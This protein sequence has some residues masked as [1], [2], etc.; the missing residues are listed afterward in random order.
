M[1]P[2]CQT[3]R[4]PSTVFRLEYRPVY[5]L[6][7]K[8]ELLHILDMLADAGVEAWWYAAAS[9]GSYPMF[10]SRH[11]PYRSDAVDVSYFHWLSEQAHQRNITLFSWEYLTTAPILAQRHPEW[12][13][14]LFDWDGPKTPR[15]HQYVCWNSPYG[16]MLK[17]YSLEVVTDCGFDGIWFDGSFLHG[18]GMT[19]R[20]ACCCE[21]CAKRYHDQTGC[22]LP[23][24]VDLNDQACR[25]YFAWR[26]DDHMRYWQELSSFVKATQP[27]AT[28]AY[29]HFNRLGG[30]LDS[31]TP[32]TKL[33]NDKTSLIATE[34][35]FHY[36]QI[37][38]LAKLLR[39]TSDHYVPELWTYLADSPIA[40]TVNPDPTPLVYYMQSC[41][42]HGTYASFGS[43]RDDIHT[44][45]QT[46]HALGDAARQIRPFIGGKS[47]AK[48]AV[49]FSNAT[50]DYAYITADGK[51]YDNATIW[52]QVC[53]TLSLLDHLHIQSDIIFDNMLNPHDLQPYDAIIL[54]SVKC[55]ADDAA[56]Q[57]TD[58]VQQGGQLLAIG[59][60]GT[61]D[62]W[63]HPRQTPVLDALFGI[64][65]HESKQTL[66]TLPDG[67]IPAGL[68][69]PFRSNAQ[70]TIDC[71][72]CLNPSRPLGPDGILPLSDDSYSHAHAICCNTV[73]NGHALYIA[74]DIVGPYACSGPSTRTR[75]LIKQ[76]LTRFVTPNVITDAPCNVV[77]NLFQNEQHLHVHL[78]DVPDALTRLNLKTPD[79]HFPDIY[80]PNSF[81]R[82]APFTLQLP[83]QWQLQQQLASDTTVQCHVADGQTSLKVTDFQQYFALTLQ[84]L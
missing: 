77:I 81:P 65:W 51:S 66:M 12:R 49:L 68:G 11:L 62:Q 9:K 79:H 37:P 52:N 55:M 24:T 34:V 76:W 57:L 39:S 47:C 29:N 3:E 71:T 41:T 28:I 6:H 69:K 50:K 10:R 42:A 56:N 59:D 31:G 27:S 61:H 40:Q 13:W 21:F 35:G 64:T 58:Y 7:S 16:Q 78:L 73:G 33:R 18:H 25:E 45:T 46:L 63:G 43:G 84:Q 82:L 5:G 53:G 48:V 38:A 54:P 36:H 44:Q 15:D 23:A 74:A 30:G 8:D 1:N 70:E 2:T 60:C 32:L 83:G 19:G 67:H 17:E 26:A 22:Q 72:Y 4:Y 75:T 14:K 80:L 20:Y